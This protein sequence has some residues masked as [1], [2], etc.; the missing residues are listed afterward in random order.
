MATTDPIA[1]IRVSDEWTG[2]LFNQWRLL[3]ASEGLEPDADLAKPETMSRFDGA[4]LVEWALDLTKDI[5]PIL[6]GIL[7]FLVAR[8]GEVEFRKGDRIYKFRNLRANQIRQVMNVIDE[9]S[10]DSKPPGDDHPKL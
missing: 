1:I 2:E 8:N 3:R 10:S 6:T 4:T 7:G 5:S 9:L